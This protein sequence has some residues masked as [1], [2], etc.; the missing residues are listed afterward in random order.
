MKFQNKT[1]VIG[2]FSTVKLT[3]QWQPTIPG[4]VRSK[5]VLSFDD[6]DSNDVS[7]Y[8]IWTLSFL[9]NFRILIYVSKV[10]F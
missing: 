5:F 1:G 7:F 3:V 8:I 6:E 10:E 2:P 9:R 4:Q